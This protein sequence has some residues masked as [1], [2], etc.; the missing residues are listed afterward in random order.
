[1]S[2]SGGSRDLERGL[3]TVVGH[4]SVAFLQHQVDPAPASPD[5]FHRLAVGHPGRALPVDLHQLVRHLRGETFEGPDLLP[6]PV[7]VPTKTEVPVCVCLSA[8]LYLIAALGRA[9]VHQPEDVQPHVVLAAAP[10]REA[11]PR[12]TSVQVHTVEFGLVLADGRTD[13][14]LAGRGPTG[15]RG[16]GAGIKSPTDL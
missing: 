7:R 5:L 3:L 10:Q 8:H 11:E 14:Q 9:P 13:R 1:M 2:G 6:R 15:S 16:F 12:G 4:V